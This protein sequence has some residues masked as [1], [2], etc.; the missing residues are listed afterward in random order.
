MFVLAS[1]KW[2]IYLFIFEIFRSRIQQLL[3]WL[4]LNGLPFRLKDFWKIPTWP[5]CSFV[6]ILELVVMGGVGCGC[7]GV[8]SYAFTWVLGI[9]SATAPIYVGSSGTFLLL[10]LVS[11]IIKLLFHIAVVIVSMQ[12]Y[13]MKGFHMHYHS[14][15]KG[16]LIQVVDQ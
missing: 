9:K 15:K 6:S 14:T 5:L 2:F 12:N 16:V 13:Q 1:W 10:C 8:F 11:S 7:A 3:V 4:L